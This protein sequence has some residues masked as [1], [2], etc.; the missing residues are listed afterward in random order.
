VVE[1]KEQQAMITPADNIPG[2]GQGRWTYM[3]YA[4]IPDDG[5][6]YEVVDGV[7]FMTP[8]PSI[9]HQRIALRIA[10]Y[11]AELIED[12]QLGHI[13]IAPVDIE[14]APKS[15]V[16]PDV[17]VVLKNGRAKITETRVI[18]APDLVVE[19]SSPATVGYDHREKLGIYAQAAI[20][21]YWLVDP[22]ARTIKI[23][24]WHNMSYSVQGSYAGEQFVV[25]Q[26]APVLNGIRCVQ[27]FP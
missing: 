6:H 14:L 4:A 8:A 1:I 25:S 2:P 5:K 17:S 11:M 16:Q 26:I 27:F 13:L 19:I 15:I 24:E 9:P 20:P 22:H 7:L 18:G 23:L 21:E 12:A 10:R 3:H